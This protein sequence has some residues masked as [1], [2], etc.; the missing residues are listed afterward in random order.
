[1]MLVLHMSVVITAI[2]LPVTALMTFILHY[3][4]SEKLIGTVKRPTAHDVIGQTVT[5]TLVL[6]AAGIDAF[7]MIDDVMNREDAFVKDR[8]LTNSVLAFVSITLLL[9]NGVGMATKVQEDMLN[10][11]FMLLTNIPLLVIRSYLFVIDD[12]LDNLEGSSGRRSAFYTLF[13][14]K[15]VLLI[16]LSLVQL[17]ANACFE[18]R[19]AKGSDNMMDEETDF[20][21]VGCMTMCTHVC[22]DM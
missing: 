20:K 18:V 8:H 15:E 12:D 19:D 5:M 2:T 1:M 10:Y 3:N 21:N 4:Y 13:I 6:L 14:V 7:S 16:S 22:N 9:T 17:V 11:G